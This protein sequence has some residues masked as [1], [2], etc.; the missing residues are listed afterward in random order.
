MTLGRSASSL[1]AGM[2]TLICTR[3]PGN[4]KPRRAIREFRAGLDRVGSHGQ[5]DLAA[6]DR[7]FAA[8]PFAEVGVAGDGMVGLLV[9]RFPVQAD[10]RV[11]VCLQTDELEDVELI[12]AVDLGLG[13]VVRNDRAELLG[14]V[15][16]PG[17]LVLDAHVEPVIP[18]QP[19]GEKREYALPARALF[20][21]RDAHGLLPEELALRYLDGRIAGAVKS[22]PFGVI[23]ARADVIHP[24]IADWEK[25]GEIRAALYRAAHGD[26]DRNQPALL[27]IRR[28]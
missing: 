9:E 2:R 1:N 26:C 21:L 15:D 22:P 20:S 23:D 8:L 12:G 18:F 16:E 5:I 11:E 14:G 4:R 10:F 7:H 6:Y 3:L 24:E 19:E 17:F 25:R 13:R 27:I 28:H